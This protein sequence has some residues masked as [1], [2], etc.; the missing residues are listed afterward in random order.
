V[1]HWTVSGALGRAA[2][3]QLTLVFLL[4]ALRY[5]SPDCPVCTGHV[6]WA[7]GATVTWRQWSTAV[8]SKNEQCASRC[9][10]AKSERT[11]HVRCATGLSGAARGQRVPMV[12]RSKPQRACL[13]GAHRT[14]NS[15]CPVRHRT[16]SCAHQQQKQPTTRKWLEA[17]N[18]PQPPPSMASKFSEVPIQY[19]S[20]SIHSKTHS[21]DQI[22]SKPQNQ[23]NHLETW[24]KE[25]CVHL[26]LL[27]LGLLC[28]PLFLFS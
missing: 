5:N 12:D 13:R 11:G 4:G 8:N 9:Q 14:V 19:K 17:I 10:A 18:T 22:L 1:A 3:E 20:N 26:L 21:K 27:L 28:P 7:N 15:T 23:L 16:V 2:L 6:W 24:E 25:F